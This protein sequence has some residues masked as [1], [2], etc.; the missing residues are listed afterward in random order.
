MFYPLEAIFAD[1][2]IYF[3]GKTDILCSYCCSLLEFYKPGKTEQRLE[4]P[5]LSILE[6]LNAV[7]RHQNL[8]ETLPK[9]C[10]AILATVD[11]LKGIKPFDYL[12]RDEI[13]DSFSASNILLTQRFLKDK[14]YGIDANFLQTSTIPEYAPAN[15]QQLHAAE[16][17]ERIY[18]LLTFYATLFDEIPQIYEKI[19]RIADMYSN[20][21]N[22]DSDFL[23][24]LAFLEFRLDAA[25]QPNVTYT[26]YISTESDGKF[27]SGKMIQFKTYTEL[28]ITE[29]FE[30]LMIGHYPRLCLV[31][32]KPF[33]K[34]DKNIQKYCTGLSPHFHDEKQLSCKQYAKQNGSP[35]KADGDPFK[36]ICKKRTECIRTEKNRGTITPE[37]AAAAT[38]LTQNHLTLALT[39]TDYTLTQYKKDLER[40]TLYK[41]T[42]EFLRNTPVVPA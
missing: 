24:S 19:R 1:K 9:A 14:G 6:G 36:V 30:S 11:I 13:R 21:D 12:D 37:F 35:E 8:E 27:Y 18:G 26:P 31:C 38:L 2:N 16:A 29:L 3:A 4:A 33:L 7:T 23:F 20:C 32:K 5:Y 41:E 34:T 15:V 42:E 22:H 39:E 17:A 40:K 10:E 25:L 28:I